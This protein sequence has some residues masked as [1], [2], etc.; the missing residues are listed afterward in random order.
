MKRLIYQKKFSY[1]TQFISDGMVC[2]GISSGGTLAPGITSY[3]LMYQFKGYTTTSVVYNS[4]FNIWYN[5]SY[6]KITFTTAPTGAL[7]TWLQANGVKQDSTLA[8]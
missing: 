6:R 3:N 4:E 5:V 8:T 2:I 7:L 1:D